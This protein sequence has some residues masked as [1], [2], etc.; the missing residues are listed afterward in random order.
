VRR[1]GLRRKAGAAGTVCRWLTR[2]GQRGRIREWLWEPLA[3]AALNDSPREAAA[4]PFIHVLRQMFTG[5]RTDASIVL[6]ATPLH[7]MYALPARRYLEQR[8]G[9]VRLNALARVRIAN[10]AIAGLDVRGEP[11]AVETV[12]AAVPWFAL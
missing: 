11:I 10:G 9:E 12:I 3:I 5:S 1:G 7:E 6:P 4:A 2:R 8:G